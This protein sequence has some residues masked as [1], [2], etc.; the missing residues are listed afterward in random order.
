LTKEQK[1]AFLDEYAQSKAVASKGVRVSA[2]SKVN[3]AAQTLEA[4]ETMVCGQ[5]TFQL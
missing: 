3:D 5:V 4:V 1:Q 2:R